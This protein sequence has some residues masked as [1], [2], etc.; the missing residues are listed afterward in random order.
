MSGVPSGS[1]TLVASDRRVGETRSLIGPRERVDQAFDTRSMD[2]GRGR[3]CGAVASPLLFHDFEIFT[4]LRG[5]SAV[6]SSIRG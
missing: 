4:Q 5:A 3:I 2:R 6:P 1:L